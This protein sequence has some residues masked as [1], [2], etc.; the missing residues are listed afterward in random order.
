MRVMGEVGRY[1]Y[2]CRTT[3]ERQALVA[4]LAGIIAN[5]LAIKTDDAEVQV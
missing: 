2:R 5:T 4:V 1:E 3:V